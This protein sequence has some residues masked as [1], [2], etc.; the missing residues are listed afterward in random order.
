ML[1]DYT[2]HMKENKQTLIGRIYGLITFEFPAMENITIVVMEN[3]QICPKA[4]KL[5]TYDM[6]GSTFHRRVHKGSYNEINKQTRV[7]GTLK[8]ED[9]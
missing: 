4:C 6:K 8:D 7:S 5:R 9:F 2:K 1:L 3:V